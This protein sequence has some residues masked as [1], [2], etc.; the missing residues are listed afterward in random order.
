MNFECENCL[1]SFKAPIFF[2]R[3]VLNMIFKDLKFKEIILD[4]DN[5]SDLFSEDEK[6]LNTQINRSKFLYFLF[7]LS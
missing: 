7:L 2:K 5:D 6:Y 4:D 1:K 3:N